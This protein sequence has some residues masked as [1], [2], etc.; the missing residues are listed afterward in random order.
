MYIDLPVN[1]NFRGLF[2]TINEDREDEL[3]PSSDDYTENEYMKLNLRVSVIFTI[4]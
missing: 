3:L 4:P 1:T 2:M